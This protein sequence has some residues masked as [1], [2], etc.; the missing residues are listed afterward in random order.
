[1]PTR[2]PISVTVR[3]PGI[4]ATSRIEIH[5]RAAMGDPRLHPEYTPHLSDADR[6]KMNAATPAVQR[7]RSLAAEMDEGQPV[8]LPA[9]FGRPFRAV[10]DTRWYQYCL[11]IHIDADDQVS[12]ASDA[13][14]I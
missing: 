13:P 14:L 11:A 3:V 2:E 1:M 10:T 6:E 4:Y 7:V 9:L 8:T 5:R 12:P